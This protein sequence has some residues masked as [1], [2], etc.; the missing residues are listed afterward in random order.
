MGHDHC[1]RIQLCPSA[2]EPRPPSL[3]AHYPIAIAITRRWHFRLRET[4][5]RSVGSLHTLFSRFA[6]GMPSLNGA[7]DGSPGTCWR[8]PVSTASRPATFSSPS[9]YWSTPVKRRIFQVISRN[10]GAA[11]R[12][13]RARHQKEEPAGEIPTAKR[14]RVGPQ[15]PLGHQNAT[16]TH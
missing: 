15:H 5:A 3:F 14:R 13:G 12:K 8:G 10:S 16:A 9:Y 6:G 11:R 4:S 7:C 1:Q 2:S